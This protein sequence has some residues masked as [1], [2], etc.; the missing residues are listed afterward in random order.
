MADAA[1][2]SVQVDGNRLD[3]GI[4]GQA[5]ILEAIITFTVQYRLAGL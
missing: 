5:Y 1:F 4:T 2:E 3:I